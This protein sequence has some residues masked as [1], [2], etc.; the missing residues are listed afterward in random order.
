MYAYLQLGL[1]LPA[2]VAAS[3]RDGQYKKTQE[4]CIKSSEENLLLKMEEG[5][6]E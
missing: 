4:V 2:K 6:G 1:K 3:M 5:W